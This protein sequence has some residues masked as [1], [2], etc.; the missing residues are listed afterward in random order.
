MTAATLALITPLN[1]EFLTKNILRG[2]CN[3]VFDDMVHVRHGAL[4]GIS[5]ILI[6]LAGKN[7]MHNMKDEMKDSIFLRSLTK[8]EKKLIKAGEHMKKFNANY[9]SLKEV[10]NLGLVDKEIM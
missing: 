10:N 3:N 6:S 4:Y 8:N 5:D 9:D 2:L 7:Y 1:P